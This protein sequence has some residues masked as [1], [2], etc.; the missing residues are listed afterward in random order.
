MKA[1]AP[2]QFRQANVLSSKKSLFNFIEE[3]LFDLEGLGAGARHRPT[4]PP[5]E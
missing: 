3:R 2:D 4:Y 1:Q 5:C